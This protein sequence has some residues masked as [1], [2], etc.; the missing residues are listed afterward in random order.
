MSPWALHCLLQTMHTAY[1]KPSLL[2][3]LANALFGVVT[4]AIENPQAFVSK[5]P[6]GL[7]SEG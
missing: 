7:C 4:K 2:G 6:G 5:A 1:G 3:K